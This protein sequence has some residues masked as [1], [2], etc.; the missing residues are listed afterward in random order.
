MR[1]YNRVTIVGTL[2]RD[3][4]RKT[5]EDGGEASNFTLAT[6]ESWTDKKTG[7]KKEETEWHRITSIGKL[8]AACNKNLKKGSKVLVEGS[9]KTRSWFDKKLK[10][11]RFITEIRID[12][13]EILSAF[14]QDQSEYSDNQ[15]DN[16]NS[17]S[18][19]E[20]HYNREDFQQ[21]NRAYDD[22]YSNQNQ[23]NGRSY[24]NQNQQNGRGFDNQNQQYDRSYHNQ[25]FRNNEGYDN[26][27]K[28]NNQGFNQRGNDSQNQN[29]RSEQ[30]QPRSSNH[31]RKNR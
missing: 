18:Y 13:M 16:N 30:D 31:E 8:A 5:F 22:G 27:N 21:P 28:R 19:N 15:G 9:L 6:T 14:N 1:G 4:E 29:N 17:N 12:R 10:I 23:Q 26:Q 7:Q 3:P 25:D 24:H 20:H 11:D 2:G